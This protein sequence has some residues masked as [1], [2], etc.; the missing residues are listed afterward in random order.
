[1]GHNTDNFSRTSG[2]DVSASTV[3]PSHTTQKHHRQCNSRPNRLSS[4][5]RPL[6]ECVMLWRDMKRQIVSRK[7]VGL[8]E[9]LNAFDLICITQGY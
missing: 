5:S 1:M 8:F 9:K 4:H 3:S 7:L 6:G 2:P